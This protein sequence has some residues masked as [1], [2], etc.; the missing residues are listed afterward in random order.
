MMPQNNI[1]IAISASF[2]QVHSYDKR[3]HDS[4][5]FQYEYVLFLSAE[6]KECPVWCEKKESKE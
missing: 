3:M 4:Y 6:V 2:D 5:L 1:Q